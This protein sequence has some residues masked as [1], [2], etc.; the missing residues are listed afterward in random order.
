VGGSVESLSN[1]FDSW[2]DTY[3]GGSHN[4]SSR[5]SV[6]GQLLTAERF[7]MRDESFM[8]GFS[9]PLSEQW[10]FSMEAADS[11]ASNFLPKW[12]LMGGAHY[13]MNYGFGVMSS[14]RH[15]DYQRVSNDVATVGIE[16]YWRNWHVTYTAYI[17]QLEGASSPVFNHVGQVSYYY[18]NHDFVGVSVGGGQQSAR[19]NPT[20]IA[21]SDT[22]VYS[23][24]GKHWVIPDL[25]VTYNASIN[26]QGSSYTRRGVALGLQYAF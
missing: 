15:S 13:K 2:N 21:N 17:S 7:A 25:A 9:Y 3:V 22:Q 23:L 24:Q 19:M 5:K 10:T 14:F 18:G 12:S 26:I 20:T 8:T 16:N 11:P 4:F 1:K 6:Y